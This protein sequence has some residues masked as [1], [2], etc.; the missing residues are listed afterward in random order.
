MVTLSVM[1][2][3]ET[4]A[5]FAGADPLDNLAVVRLRQR[6]GTARQEPV[7]QAGDLVAELAGASVSG[8]ANGVL[9]SDG[10]GFQVT[11]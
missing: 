5:G 8:V 6:D 4:H 3:L 10:F 2:H 9:S 11:S 7:K 1:S